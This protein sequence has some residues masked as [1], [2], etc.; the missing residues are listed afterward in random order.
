MI[1]KVLSLSIEIVRFNQ[2]TFLVGRVLED[3]TGTNTSCLGRGW[4]LIRAV[5]T[6]LIVYFIRKIRRERKERRT[7][8]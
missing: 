7:D 1:V 6:L 4:F 2:E 8:L 3:P 5:T